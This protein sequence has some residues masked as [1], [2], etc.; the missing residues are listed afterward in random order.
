MVSEARALDA[1]DIIKANEWSF[2]CTSIF[3]CGKDDAALRFKRKEE[4]VET[5]PAQR[6]KI[7]AEIDHV[8]KTINFMNVD[9]GKFLVDTGAQ[10]PLIGKPQLDSLI[11]FRKERG[12]PLPIWIHDQKAYTSG[13]G[14]K[15]LLLGEVMM[16]LGF[17]QVN[18]KCIM[19]V[20]DENVPPIIPM[21]ML[22]DLG[23]T[24]S[25]STNTITWEGV[26][27]LGEESDSPHPVSNCRDAVAA[28]PRRRFRF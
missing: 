3:P 22:R 25:S 5:W 11:E 24:I 4:F 8:M 23:A 17:A 2:P 1:I 6:R 27:R 18:G 20:A 9:P 19:K 10:V 28:H 26:R 13:I 12:L 15:C 16:P 7:V 21:P 14:G